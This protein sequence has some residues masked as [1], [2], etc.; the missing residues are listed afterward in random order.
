MKDI[1]NFQRLLLLRALRP[2]RLTYALSKYVHEVMGEEYVEQ[3]AF[4]MEL[5]FKESSSTTPIF[6]VLFPG[7]DPTKDV[8]RI[9][10][11]FDVSSTNGR[12]INIS[13]G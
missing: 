10:E 6:F 3:P 7:V 9:G 13:M 12:F 1:N 4:N 5:T 2:D 11:K 8:E